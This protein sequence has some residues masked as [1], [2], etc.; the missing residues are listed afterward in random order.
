MPVN[1]YDE[2]LLRELYLDEKLSVEEIAIE[3]RIGNKLT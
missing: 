1:K 3:A 2:N